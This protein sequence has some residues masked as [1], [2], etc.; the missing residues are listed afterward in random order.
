MRRP[1]EA[2]AFDDGLSAAALPLSVDLDGVVVGGGIAIGA[3]RPR[4]E[5]R[6]RAAASPGMMSVVDL[7]GAGLGP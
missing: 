4:N 1:S 2:S 7:S 6:N 5:P 3:Q